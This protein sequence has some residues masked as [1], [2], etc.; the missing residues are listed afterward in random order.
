MHATFYIILAITSAFGILF[1]KRLD[2]PF[3]LLSF[4]IFTVLVSEMINKYLVTKIGTNFPGMHVFSYVGVIFN[5]LIYDQVLKD[6]L[7]D[8]KI[9]FSTTVIA[10]T[11]LILNLIYLEGFFEFPSH[12]LIIN[13][14]QIVI[15][16]FLTYVKLLNNN[17]KRAI[18]TQATFWLN[19]GNFLFYGITFNIFAFF[20]YL[21]IPE[22]IDW[23][24][25]LI[26]YA[27]FA[28]YIFFF[29]A[30]VLNSNETNE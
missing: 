21:Y 10:I 13:A 5:G 11:L 23:T 1:I 6:N 2:N 28:M 16:V 24:Y 14:F 9:V 12:G 25:A 4:F 3:K 15:F 18:Y 8:R 29:I 7:R 17:H 26:K 19:S 27:N 20:N 22:N 30:I